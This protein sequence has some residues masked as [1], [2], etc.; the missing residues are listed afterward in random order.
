MYGKIT[1]GALIYPKR[2]KQIIK[3]GNWL[4][5]EKTLQDLLDEGFKRLIF[6][7]VEAEEGFE[8]IPHYEENGE[9]IYVT[10]TQQEIEGYWEQKAEAEEAQRQAEEAERKKKADCE[11]LIQEAIR[12]KNA[13]EYNSAKKKLDKARKMKITEKEETISTIEQEVVRL[14]S[15][16]SF[17]GNFSKK[18]TKAIETVLDEDKND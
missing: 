11:E 17:W 14:K 12:L 7:D 13:G 6:E 15:E 10:Y 9:K 16:N 5:V 8:L 4:V 3:D 18:V 1:N 2:T